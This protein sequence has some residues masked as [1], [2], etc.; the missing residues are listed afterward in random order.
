MNQ[1]SRRGGLNRAIRKMG[2]QPQIQTV[3]E[4]GQGLQNEK[5]ATEGE[6]R[7]EART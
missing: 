5:E 6:G 7:K 4:E 3:T 2:Q 1:A